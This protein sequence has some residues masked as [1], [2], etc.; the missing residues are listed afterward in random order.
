VALRRLLVLV[1]LV[2]C[3]LAL[4]QSRK[5]LLIP[6]D[7]RPAVGHFAA[8]IGDVAGVE[9]VTPPAA[10]LGK[11][12]QPGS[13]PSILGWLAK[14]DISQYEA[15]VVSADMIAYGGLI[16]SRTDRSSET[17]AKS[18]L[19]E[20]WKIRKSSFKTPFYIF[21]TLTRIAPT[22]IAEN[23]AWRQDLYYWAI[24]SEQHRLKGDAE[25]KRKMQAH[26]IKIP[27][28]E[29]ERYRSVRA[30]NVAVQAEILKMT[31]HG[32]FNHVTLGQDDAAPQ[33]PHVPE[34]ALLEKEVARLKLSHRAQFC[35]GIDQISNCLVSRAL[36]DRAQWSPKVAI[37]S[38]DR[39]GLDQIA[40]YE[41]EPIRESL[42]DQLLTSGARLVERAED[43][44]YILFLN[45]PKRK[46][47]EF[48]TF[49]QEMSAS[50]T[51][52]KKIAVADANLGWSGTADPALFEAITSRRQGP[53]LVSYAGWNTAGNTMGTTIPAANAYL[54]ALK[55]GINPLRREK[56]ARKFVLHRL[57][58]DYFYNRYVRPE[59]YRMIERMQNGNREE[60]SEES[61]VEL[62]ESYVKK[63]MAE[64]LQQTFK[65]QMIAQPF[66]A[67]EK[68]YLVVA[69]DRITVEL[70]WPRAYEVHLDF[71]LVVRE[72][73]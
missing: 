33:G 14:Q 44:D 5:I 24:F 19:R 15:V 9:V 57:V 28:E 47:G 56:A 60:I 11:F 26:E 67:G 46:D 35:M 41:T 31:F 59:A 4:G 32:A 23:R 50:I 54:I 68:Q 51:A 13:P 37:R 27:N 45:T 72:A 30:R 66:T 73:E 38:A 20:L 71:D 61:N 48:E 1:G 43:A 7:D 21:S 70:P 36:S 3:G 10:F 49:V 8:M 25:S 62:V 17:L 12:K 65:E 64:K 22:A 18:R 40:A 63:D 34:I 58:T 42:S 55:T 16:A 39:A 69:L 6:V 2:L 29:R 53:Q 52:G